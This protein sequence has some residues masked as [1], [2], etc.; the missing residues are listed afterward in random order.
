MAFN[1]TQNVQQ[2][3]V[4]PGT[5]IRGTQTPTQLELFNRDGTPWNPDGATLE[6]LVTREEFEDYQTEVN[7]RLEALEEE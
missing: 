1:D 2:A 4:I 5:A 3:Y 7:G 6:G